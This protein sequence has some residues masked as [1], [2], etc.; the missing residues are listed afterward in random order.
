[1]AE[2]HLLLI[3]KPIFKFSEGAALNLKFL[4]YFGLEVFRSREMSLEL[5]EFFN[6]SLLTVRL[7]RPFLRLLLKTFLPE[8]EAMRFLNPCLLLRFLLLILI[9]VFI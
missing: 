3:E 9:V 2:P 8:T 1:M 7:F 6:Y 5:R 4:L